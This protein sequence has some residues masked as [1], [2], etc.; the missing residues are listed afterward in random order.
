MA[1]TKV[2]SG[3]P[4]I[5]PETGGLTKE[6]QD[7]IVALNERDKAETRR[8]AEGGDPLLEAVKDHNKTA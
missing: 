7:A 3:L 8:I 6:A 2:Q 4:L 1:E 5:N